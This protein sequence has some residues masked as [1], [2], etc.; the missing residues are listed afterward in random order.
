MRFQYIL[1]LKGNGGKLSWGREGW[2]RVRQ[3]KWLP[4]VPKGS[5]KLVLAIPITGCNEDPYDLSRQ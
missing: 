1:K 4:L 5:G 2:R 3:D